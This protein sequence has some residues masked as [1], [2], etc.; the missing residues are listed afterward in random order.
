M[1]K[2]TDK[3]NIIKYLPFDGVE[4]SCESAIECYE[5]AGLMLAPID[6]IKNTVPQLARKLATDSNGVLDEL[7]Y[8]GIMD[9]YGFCLLEAAIYK[10]IL[11]SNEEIDYGAED[12]KR[13]FDKCWSALCDTDR[14][15]LK[16]KNEVI[17]EIEIRVKGK[18][19]VERIGFPY[20]EDLTDDWKDAYE[21]EYNTDDPILMSKYK[22]E[23]E[24]ICRE[25]QKIDNVIRRY[26]HW[27]VGAPNPKLTPKD[28][29]FI[30]VRNALSDYFSLLIGDCTYLKKRFYGGSTHRFYRY[31]MDNALY[32]KM[33]GDY[34]TSDR[35]RVAK[36]IIDLYQ[37][38]DT[39]KA[40]LQ[41]MERETTKEWLVQRFSLE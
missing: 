1:N 36:F 18:K 20:I 13:K 19:K 15:V 12:Y 32:K 2:I 7:I 27:P 17:E 6:Y 41:Y 5:E 10:N 3:R 33:D 21:G 14:I 34:R 31:L 30:I 16:I 40:A 8:N 39:V 38:P 26:I 35:E 37:L 4:N 11:K 24:K 29:D 9:A 25:R 23:Y 22:D 28:Q